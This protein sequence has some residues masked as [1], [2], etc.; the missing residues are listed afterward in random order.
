MKDASDTTAAL[1]DRDKEIVRSVFE[2]DTFKSI[3]LQHGI[4]GERVR[5][6]A[7]PFLAEARE[8]RA[9]VQAEKVQH[10]REQAL[11]RVSE[12]AR[13]NP[14]MTPSEI[15]REIGLITSQD[16][17]ERL[18]EAD[19][20][21]RQ[22]AVRP[23]LGRRFTYEDAKQAL[24]NASDDDLSKPVTMAHYRSVAPST[25]PS[26]ET[27]L[28]LYGSWHAAC[29]DAGVPAGGA[30]KDQGRSRWTD[31]ELL[32]TAARFFDQKGAQGSMEAY[33]AWSKKQKRDTPSVA[34]LRKR[35]G[36]WGQ[37]RIRVSSLLAT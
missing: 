2:G 37:V 14:D 16:V 36:S 12:V 3:G 15:A 23:A 29:E 10:K 21:R 19:V 4:S 35:F 27:I 34:L 26:A 9:A 28:A 11:G 1:L 8:K 24:R 6:I 17:A 7:L 32:T 31:E 25:G 33:A 13:D 22:A 30:A 18:P 20:L 5:Q